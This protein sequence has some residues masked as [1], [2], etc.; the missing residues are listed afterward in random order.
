ME[1]IYIRLFCLIL[2]IFSFITIYYYNVTKKTLKFYPKKELP[3]YGNLNFIY[4]EP[5]KKEM[6]R[7]I[8]KEA[9]SQFSEELIIVAGELR[10]INDPTLTRYASS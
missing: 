8:I 1:N 3:V 7:T 5:H 2:G 6:F 10:I 4:K 9:I